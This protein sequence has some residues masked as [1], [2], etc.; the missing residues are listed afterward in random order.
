MDVTIE[1]DT[2][3][4]LVLPE[5]AGPRRRHV[6][7][8][9]NRTPDY[10]ANYDD[11]TLF[12]DCVRVEDRW[13]FAAP[14]F[15]NLWPLFRDGLRLDGRRPAGLR[16]RRGRQFELVELRAPEGALSIVID[17]TEH[18]VS[19]RR[20]LAPRFAGLNCAVTMNRDNPL[21]WIRD[22]ARYHVDRHG[23]Q[24]V[25]IFDNGSTTYAPGD[26]ADALSTV[27]GLESA[28]VLSAPFPFGLTIR[29]G[30][31]ETVPLFLQTATLNLAK[32]DAFR[33]ARS[34]LNA[35]I[36]ELVRSDPG[37]SVFDLAARHPL[38]MVTLT[39]HWIDP[40]PEAEPPV[41]HRE[42]FHVTATPRK[43]GRKWCLRRGG[44]M[45]R[46]AWGVHQVG[47][48]LQNHFTNTDA[49]TLLHCRGTSTGWKS[50]RFRRA[51]GLRPDPELRAYL[52]EAFPE[53]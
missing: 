45:D 3:R 22:W 11:S 41:P 53:A 5:G 1:R 28:A 25:L 35:D 46:F 20:S 24:G 48:L 51:E 12:Y 36:D 43:C 10:L 14:P 42:N 13:I 17:G 30:R 8:P 47:G 23:L 2:L 33:D 31:F 9:A 40:G 49:A 50:G 34:V 6:L 16:R 4:G 21:A 26:I 38:G 52:A 44:V 18:P 29:V 27:R 15:L 37:I 19:P 32:A 7:R 39:G